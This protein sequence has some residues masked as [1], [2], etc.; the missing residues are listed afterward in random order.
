MNK[1]PLFILILVT[2]FITS[3]NNTGGNNIFIGVD[4]SRTHEPFEYVQSFEDSNIK[5]FGAEK[6]YWQ[7]FEPTATSGYKWDSYDNAIKN[8]EAIG[9]IMYPTIWSVSSWATK[10]PSPEKPASAP[11]HEDRYFKFIKAFIERYD[12][13]NIDDMPGLRYAHN[14]LQIEDEAENLGDAWTGSDA[15]NTYEPK[16]HD[17][18]RCAAQEYGEMLK[19]AYKAAHEANTNSKIISFSFNPGD[20]FDNNPIVNQRLSNYKLAFLD[21]VYENYNEYFDII[22]IQCNYDYTGIIPWINYIKDIYKLDKPIMCSD[23]ASMPL[24]GLNQFNPGDKYKNKYPFMSDNEILTVLIEKSENYVEIKQWWESEKAKISV[25]KA[26][27]AAAAGVELIS[28]QFIMTGWKSNNV[29]TLSDMLSCGSKCGDTESAGTARPVVYALGQLNENI[30]DFK[31]IENLNPIPVGENPYNW[32]WILKF[33]D[34]YVVWYDGEGEKV[35]DLSPYSTSSQLKANKLITD[36][37][38]NHKPIYPKE[39]I[40]KTNSVHVDDTPLF[41]EEI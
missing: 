2:L 23:S 3:C 20:Y 16:S 10:V 12:N 8:V 25:K 37:D 13:D 27:A 28:F 17:R 21:E 19:L 36:L 1:I 29:W 14:Y 18:Q 24:L 33:E 15:C 30:S 6:E 26:V 40:F 38:E 4:A 35:F 11:E 32:F 22:G 39:E 34:V 5:I 41:I 31:T 9:G 7:D